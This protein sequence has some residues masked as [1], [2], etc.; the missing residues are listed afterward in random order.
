MQIASHPI[1]RNPLPLE[2]GD[3]LARDLEQVFEHEAERLTRRLLHRQG[4]DEPIAHDQVIAITVDSRISDEVVEVTIARQA[5]HVGGLSVIVQEL[6]EK[7]ERVHFV[8]PL[9]AKVADLDLK[10]LGGL[11]QRR[12][13]AVKFVLKDS[14][15]V[16]G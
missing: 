15:C 5:R 4:L 11:M 14:P 7:P 9:D 3:Q 8:E 6:A 10:R 12:D 16:I 1:A 2:T 13:R